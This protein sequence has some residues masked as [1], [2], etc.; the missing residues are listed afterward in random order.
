MLILKTRQ[1]TYKY[2]QMRQNLTFDTSI[3]FAL[4]KSVFCRLCLIRKL[5]LCH[6]LRIFLKFEAISY[7]VQLHTDVEMLK[8][9]NSFMISRHNFP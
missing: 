4:Y 8:I 7:G 2:N 5:T 3:L 6:L 1:T 9:F